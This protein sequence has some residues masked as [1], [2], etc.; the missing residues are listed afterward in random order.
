MKRPTYKEIK[1]AGKKSKRAALDMSIRKY[2]YLLQLTLEEVRKLDRKFLEYRGCSMCTRYD[3]GDYACPLPGRKCNGTCIPEWQ[4][5]TASHAQ[6]KIYFSPE[7]S[8]Y[9]FMYYAG[10]TLIKL[11]K[12]KGVIE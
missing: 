9:E 1:A 8:Y 11:L 3:K 6:I 10:Q 5:M 4:K 7:A 12:L 2:V